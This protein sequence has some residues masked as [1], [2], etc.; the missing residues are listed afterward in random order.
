MQ[1]MLFVLL[2]KKSA[3][4]SAYS[5]LKILKWAQIYVNVSE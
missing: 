3:T 1:H 2:D 5:I 4:I